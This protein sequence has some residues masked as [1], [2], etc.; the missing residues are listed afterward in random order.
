MELSYNFRFILGDKKITLPWRV[1]YGSQIKFGMTPHQRGHFFVSLWTVCLRHHLRRPAPAGL[2][3][4]PR[5]FI[6][7]YTGE[8]CV[9]PRP[10]L[11]SGVAL[12]FFASLWTV[13]LRHHLQNFLNSILRSTDFLFFLVQQFRCLQMLQ[14]SFINFSENLLLAIVEDL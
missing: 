9:F 4:N 12:Y 7:S 13:C 3:K 5:F 6:V 11:A 10:P 1:L 2:L 8:R 14:R